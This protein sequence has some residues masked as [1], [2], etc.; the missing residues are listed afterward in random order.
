[1]VSIQKSPAWK[2]LVQGIFL[3]C[4][5]VA[6]SACQ[7]T[8]ATPQAF[9][10]TAVV[11]PAAP[12]AE[13][14]TGALESTSA[15]ADSDPVDSKISQELI[16]DDP[17][18]QNTQELPDALKSAPR[19]HL[20]LDVDYTNHR[21]QGQ[22]QVTYTN[23][24]SDPL[25][26]LF[27]RLYPN[28][29]KS[30]GEGS[31]AVESVLLNGLTV[32]PQLSLE[33]TVLE[34]PLS[35]ALDPGDQVVVNFTFSG[36]IPIDF[37]IDQDDGSGGYGI[38]NSNEGVTTLSGWFPMLAVYDQDGW[39][40]D[41][42]SNIGDFVYSD[43]AYFTVDLTTPG[44]L[45]VAA[46]GVLQII[47][48]SGDRITRRYS[49]G[50]GRDFAVVMSPDFKI[51][52]VSVDGVTV[53]SYFLPGH[54]HAGAEALQIASASLKIYDSLFGPYPYSE[55]DIVE[56]P[57][58]YA[59]GVE[60]P[61]LVLVRSNLY[62]QPEDPVFV[63]TATHETA[64]QWWYNVVG[65]DVFDEPWLDEALATYSSALFSEFEYG[66]SAAQGYYEYLE[67]SL[68]T[69][70]SN[71]HD[72]PVNT[73]LS[74]FEQQERGGAY[75]STVYT[76]GALFLKAIREQMGDEFFFDALK[77]Y[78]GEHQFSIATTD[79]LLRAFETTAGK[80]LGEL[81]S[82]WVTTDSFSATPG[83]DDNQALT[84][85]VIGDYG[86]G[87][88]NAQAVADLVKSWTPDLIITVGDNNY[89][90]G[91]WETI[92]ANI[93]QF[94]AEYIH[95]YQGDYGPGAAANAFYPTPGNHDWNTDRLQ[96]YL[97]YFTL[98][99]NEYYYDFRA[100]PVHFFALDTD[101]RT[102]DGV[103]MS[104]VQAQWLKERLA[105]SDAVW[106]VVYGHVPPYS[107][108][109]HGSVDW[110]RWP[111]KEW[112]ATIYLSGH[113][114]LF[115]RL[116]VDGFPYIINGLG[117]GAIYYFNQPLPGSQKRFT[118]E[119]GALLVTANVE[120]ITFQFITTQG[121]VV[122]SYTIQK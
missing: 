62:D 27:F 117:G 2:Q 94:Y 118:G 120:E 9:S 73:S 77:Q 55:F 22:S 10:Q 90:D 17:L 35:P 68:K 31:L 107:S 58:R 23:Q 15:A 78:Y 39:N 108:G 82:Q 56:A 16:N 40:L 63:T 25:D 44:D 110:I 20:A 67:N 105:A 66:A 84:F 54:E 5:I 41:A 81:Y 113:D 72:A 87:D 71:G 75:A 89:P 114:H 34:I 101:S 95:P 43:A 115:E 1:M 97:E 112:G 60:F 18:R 59:L 65:N 38:Y 76:K 92:D 104:S 57:L 8:K 83:F 64:H 103:G 116:E 50:P 53:T 19:Y 122:D 29:K 4:V 61:G 51:E 36:S 52:Q 11:Q 100:G 88:H 26:Q 98:P 21:F 12:T 79:D 49:S 96:P 33:D 121:N 13:N 106:K 30:Y 111:F 99:G 3:G 47:Q 80:P 85:A 28:G 14:Q 69:A 86:S 74:S 32:T 7:T 45:V 46:T 48:Q 6:L 42:V 93:G 24:E 102:P 119:Y 91:Y 37:S 70:Q 109:T